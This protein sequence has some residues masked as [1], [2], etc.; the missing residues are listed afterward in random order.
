MVYVEEKSMSGPD[1]THL[2][3]AGWNTNYEE[4]VAWYKGIS[5][6]PIAFR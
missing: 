6:L 5:M 1:A 2:N 3:A 4:H